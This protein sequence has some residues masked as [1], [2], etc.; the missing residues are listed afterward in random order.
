MSDG[1]IVS[2]D[3]LGNQ[4]YVGANNPLPILVTGSGYKDLGLVIDGSIAAGATLSSN[5]FDNVSWVRNI[6]MLSQSD[7]QYD[8]QIYVRDI[9]GVGTSSILAAYTPASNQAANGTA[10]RVT[11]LSGTNA[12]LGYSVQF[13]LKNSSASPNTFAR[14]RVQILGQ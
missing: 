11:Q 9:A 8:I 2:I 12:L 10:W 1:R 13:R 4:N 5:W 3:S 14:L 6:V 7:Q